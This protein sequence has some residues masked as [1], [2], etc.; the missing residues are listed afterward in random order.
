MAH[1]VPQTQELNYPPSGYAPENLGSGYAPE[2][3]LRKTHPLVTTRLILTFVVVI[4][5]VANLA[6]MSM[7]ATSGNALSTATEQAQEQTP[8]PMAAA[9]A[10]AAPPAPPPALPTTFGEGRDLGG[11]DIAPGTYQT[12]GPSGNLDCYWERL[13]D[14]NGAAD[15]I[16]ANNLG[17]GPATVTIEESDAAFQTRW[18]NTWSKVG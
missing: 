12:A 5:I 6:I 2:E 7:A 17:L 3:K 13:K 9:P 11:T 8:P 10:P 15:S 14:T 16:I 18:C 1:P 4:I